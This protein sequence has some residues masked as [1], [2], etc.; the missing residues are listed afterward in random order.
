MCNV[1]A[2]NSFN[3]CAVHVYVPL[4]MVIYRNIKYPEQ[5]GKKIMTPLPQDFKQGDKG[6]HKPQDTEHTWNNN[7]HWKYSDFISQK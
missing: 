5:R 7:K 2:L 3:V 1:W 4:E 6:Y